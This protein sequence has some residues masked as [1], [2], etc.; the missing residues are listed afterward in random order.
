MWNWNSIQQK[1]IV[2]LAN[3]GQSNSN[4]RC[5]ND[6]DDVVLAHLGMD[7]TRQRIEAQAT[8][9]RLIEKHVQGKSKSSSSWKGVTD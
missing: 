3:A 4:R 5:K 2:H 9:R 7:C 1:F 8:D 6:K